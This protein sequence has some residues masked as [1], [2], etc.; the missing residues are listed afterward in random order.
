MQLATERVIEVKHWNDSLFSFRTTRDPG[1]RFDS[2]HFV[3]VGL[4]V[5]GRPLMRAYSI[6]SAHY[7]EHLEFFSIK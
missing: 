4:E 5:D 2:G 7:E 1:F 6:A 3:M